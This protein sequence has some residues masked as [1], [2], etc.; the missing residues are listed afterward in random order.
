[1]FSSQLDHIIVAAAD[2]ASGQRFIEHTL[3]VSVPA[4]GEHTTMATHNCVMQLGDNTYFEIIS[5]N[6]QASPPIHPRWFALDQGWMRSALSSGPRL[7]HWAINTTD[8]NAL[9]GATSLPL[10]V[11]T[12]LQ[13][14]NLRW[15]VGLPADG[16]LPMAGL[17]P[18]VIE[19]MVKPHPASSM[20][21]LGCRF[22]KLEIFHPRAEWISQQ[23]G[24]IGISERVGIRNI[25][26][27]EPPWFEVAIESP[28]GLVT[29][30][31]RS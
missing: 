21:D 19:W 9:M 1:M 10:G 22:R 31:S 6:P 5:I 4:G 28:K 18:S 24:V 8:I 25:D 3:G 16:S 23:L 15:R 14:G 17:L 26:D 30:S 12:E 7:I 27:S 11:P 2:L 20:T 13:R 29:L